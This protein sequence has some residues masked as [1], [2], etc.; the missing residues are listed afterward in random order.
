MISSRRTLIPA[1]SCNS[2]LDHVFFTS[3]AITV[4]RSGKHEPATAQM[5][6]TTTHPPLL[7]LCRRL[8]EE[9]ACG[10]NRHYSPGTDPEIPPRTAAFCW[11]LA[12]SQTRHRFTASPHRVKVGGTSKGGE[13]AFWIFT[14]LFLR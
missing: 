11:L 7:E 1:P 14:R 12:L 4:R 3:E 2:T 13:S 8:G 10:A 9:R 6:A 5:N